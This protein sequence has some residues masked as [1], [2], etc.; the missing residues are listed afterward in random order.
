LKVIQS[1]LEEIHRRKFSQKE[2]AEEMW[3]AVHQ[4]S[5]EA[6][7]C[8]GFRWDGGHII[9]KENGRRIGYQDIEHFGC[10]NYVTWIL[11][12]SSRLVSSYPLA[13]KTYCHPHRHQ[14]TNFTVERDHSWPGERTVHI[15]Q[16]GRDG[17]EKLLDEGKMVLPRVARLPEEEEVIGG[18]SWK[19]FAEARLKEI[20]EMQQVLATK[21]EKERKERQLEKA[22]A[23]GS[24]A[25][26]PVPAHCTTT[27]KRS[28]GSSAGSGVQRDSVGATVGATKRRRRR[29]P[30]DVVAS[31][32]GGYTATTDSGARA[33]EPP[34]D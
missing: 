13:A 28:A 19:D 17:F 10:K 1:T 7:D 31:A 11:T 24:D 12:N 33:E 16:E 23:Q 2:S 20:K 34:V 32:S 30:G 6:L 5:G 3:R 29:L 26:R 8:L 25:N 14:G 15:F 18:R 9:N 27:R 4:L 21:R 22:G